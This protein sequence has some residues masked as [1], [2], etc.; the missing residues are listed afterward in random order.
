MNKKY[1]NILTEELIETYIKN[2]EQDNID[3]DFV[4]NKETGVMKKESDANTYFFFDTKVDTYLDKFKKALFDEDLES[5]EKG[6]DEEKEIMEDVREFLLKICKRI[7]EDH[8]EEM[9]KIIRKIVFN[10]KAAEEAIPLNE[11]DVITIDIMDCSSIPEPYKYTLKIG[12]EK[13]SQINTDKVITFVH[14]RQEDTGMDIDTILSIEKKAGN[15]VFESVVNLEAG[16]KYLHDI[17]M[18]LFIDYSK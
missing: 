12:K 11:I 13:E 2:L 9:K 14:K 17:S 3:Y 1:I 16:R 18:Y 5:L 8:Y 4:V 6:S 10:N 15:P 7:T